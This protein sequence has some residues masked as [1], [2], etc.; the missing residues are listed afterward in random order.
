MSTSLKYLL[1]KKRKSIK[2]FVQKNKLNNYESLVE[3]C[4]KRGFVPC[5]KEEYEETLPKTQQVVV[6]EIKPV[7]RK[8]SK[9]RK[10]KKDRNDSRTK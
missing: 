7:K 4:K 10:T 8:I 6:K 2:E 5:T 3:Y 9:T 1:A